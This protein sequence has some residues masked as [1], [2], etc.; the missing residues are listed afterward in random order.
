LFQVEHIHSGYGRV[1]VLTDVSLKV[2]DGEIVSIIG[3]NGAG[4]STLL[5][6]ISALLH[7]SQGKIVFNGRGIDKLPPHKIIGL[8]IIQVPEGR[9]IIAE[10]TIREN[11]L[12]GCYL[13]Y[14]KLGPSRR[15]ALLDYVCDLFP[16][17]KDRMDQVAGTLSGGEQ[18]MLAIGRALM[19]EPKLLLTDEPSLGL[20]PM[21]VEAV[22]RVLLELNKQGLTIIMV[23]QN[24]LIALE[25][26]QRAYILEGGRIALEGAGKD[27][28]KDDR[29]RESY[30]GI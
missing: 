3:A 26:A 17:L 21:V 9:Q 23:E 18:Q 27:L 2:G 14:T 19:A 15:Q 7:C 12:L 16:I 28:L 10:L 11:L 6:T 25:M 8:G 13:R 24:A 1:K 30:L 5:K 20:A 29:V 4:K 22:C